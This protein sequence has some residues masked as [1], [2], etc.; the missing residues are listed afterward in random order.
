MRALRLAGV[1]IATGIA[2]LLRWRGHGLASTDTGL[3]ETTGMAPQARICVP[4]P[5]SGNPL[6]LM[7]I[8]LVFS[9]W[10]EARMY[11]NDWISMKLTK[12]WERTSILAS[13]LLSS[14]SLRSLRLKLSP[15]AHTR[16][17]VSFWSFGSLQDILSKPICVE[18]HEWFFV[19]ILS[20]K[21]LSPYSGV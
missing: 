15:R 8:Y 4:G 14:I 9:L 13:I 18:R 3:A 6:E 12:L 7:S 5:G 21:H 11:A 17:V 10:A 1:S 2:R 16:I 19:C 20:I